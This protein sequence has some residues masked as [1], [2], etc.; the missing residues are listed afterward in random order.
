MNNIFDFV[1]KEDLV[2]AILDFKHFAGYQWTSIL[3]E[4]AEFIIDCCESAAVDKEWF[5]NCRDA[6][7]LGE[8][9]SSVVF[10]EISVEANDLIDDW[11]FDEDTAASRRAISMLR[12]IF[13]KGI[14]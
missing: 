10:N 6:L 2:E 1:S 9:K 7:K 4:E 14:C 5:S 8:L 3:V 12:K 13:S 11:E